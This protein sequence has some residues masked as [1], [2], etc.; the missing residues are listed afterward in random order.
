M[1]LFHDTIWVPNLFVFY[2]Q[3]GVLQALA[4]FFC[5]FVPH[6]P[7]QT[8]LLASVPKHVEISK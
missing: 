2:G 4:G 5:Y 8:A 3:I 6:P 1:S 7:P